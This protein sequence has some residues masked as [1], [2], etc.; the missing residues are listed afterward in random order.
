MAVRKINRMRGPVLWACLWLRARFDVEYLGLAVPGLPKPEHRAIQADLQFLGATPERWRRVTEER[1]RAE[2]DLRR[3]ARMLDD[4]LLDE[5]RAQIGAGAAALDVE[6]VR[7]LVAVYRADVMQV[8]THLSSA[9][10]LREMAL[11]ARKSDLKP[12]V[13]WPR[14]L[15]RRRFQRWWRA[16]G[17]GDEEDREAAWRA[18]VHGHHQGRQAL[19][20]HDQYGSEGARAEGIVRLTGVLRHVGRVSE[21]LVSLRAIQT[22]ALIDMR[23]YRTHVYRLGGYAE[24]GDSPRDW[25]TLEGAPSV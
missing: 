21:Q 7:A 16:G 6:S 13:V 2:W 24:D 22:L 5:L 17:E 18:L 19:G 4:G 25:L 9:E 14:P 8:R 15:L 3:I 23:N 11:E 1:E 20:I 10:I 12:R